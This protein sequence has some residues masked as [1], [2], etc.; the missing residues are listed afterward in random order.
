M[1]NAIYENKFKYKERTWWVSLPLSLSQP[2]DV[3]YVYPTICDTGDDMGCMDIYNPDLRKAALDLITT[4]AGVFSKTANIFAPYYRQMAKDSLG[5]GQLVPDNDSFKIGYSDILGAFE[6]YIDELNT[7][8]PFFLAGH[9]QGT[10][11]LI[12]LMKDR[13][14]DEDLQK[15]L[16][17]AYLIGYSIMPSDV[18]ECPWMKMAQHATDTGVIITYNTEE[19]NAGESPVCFDGTYCINPLSW[20]TDGSLADQSL[21]KGAVFFVEEEYDSV[22]EDSEYKEPYIDD[23]IPFYCDAQINMQTGAL[24]TETPD[25]LDAGG[26]PY[27]VLHRYDYELWYRNLENNVIERW[28]AYSMRDCYTPIHVD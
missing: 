10:M 2:V 12:Q 7:D 23:E 21:N 26:M 8:R 4:Q 14:D 5:D 11:T 20:R 3:F 1:S 22:S 17:G 19:P 24:V 27:G 15:R 6:Y 13:F 18:E 16:V 25:D 9:S 28:N